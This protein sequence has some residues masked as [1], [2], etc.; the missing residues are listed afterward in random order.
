MTPGELAVW[1]AVYAVA[2]CGPSH[3]APVGHVT[4]GWRVGHAAEEAD[5]AVAALRRAVGADDDWA[6]LREVIE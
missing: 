4:D 6:K 5:R 2:W 3:G 1:R